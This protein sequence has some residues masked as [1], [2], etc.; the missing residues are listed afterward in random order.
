MHI[1]KYGQQV[2]TENDICNLLL[3][4]PTRNIENMLVEKQIY[5]NDMFVDTDNLPKLVQYT[6]SKLTV[7]EFD[8]SQPMY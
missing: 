6:T 7:Q 8:F 2:Y 4:D 3:Q 5:F 1:D